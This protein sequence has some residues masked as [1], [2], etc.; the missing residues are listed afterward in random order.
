MV[1]VVKDIT[2][3]ELSEHYPLG[4][5]GSNYTFKASF[6]LKRYT[7]IPSIIEMDAGN[8]EFT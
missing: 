4:S 8:K 7:E 5:L 1:K 3:F 6:G 2:E